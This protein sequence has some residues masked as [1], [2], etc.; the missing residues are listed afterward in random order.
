[1][2][3][4][5]SL[6]Q[7]VVVE[8]SLNSYTQWCRHRV[9]AALN[10]VLPAQSDVSPTLLEAMKYSLFNGGKRIRPL[11]VYAS[12]EA[13]K[14]DY[15]QA[16][17]L[18]CAVELIHAYSLVHDDLPAMDDD[19]M[20]RGKPTCHKVYGEGMAI[21]V[22]DALQTAAFELLSEHLLSAQLSDSTRINAM[23]CLSRAS[24]IRGMAAGQ[25]M[26]QFALGALLTQTQLEQMHGHKTGALISAAIDMGSMCAAQASADQQR[27]LTNYAKVL[28][29]AFQVWDDVI[30]VTSNTE[31]LGKMQGADERL[32]KPTYVK[33]M[34]L[35]EAQRYA[36]FLRDEAIAALASFDGSADRLRQ[37]ADYVVQRQH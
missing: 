28:G 21:L 15:D 37:I 27:A 13:V 17:P 33:L 18:A 24:G 1:M 5:V 7:A 32:N 11:L 20:R 6:A 2:I 26:D 4:D 14:G 12:C 16:L 29:L 36:F 35:T 9:D 34:G 22:G 10:Q 19:D 3:V 30:D 25:A 8:Q 31:V 23:R